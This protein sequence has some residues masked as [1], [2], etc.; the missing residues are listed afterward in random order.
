M[1]DFYHMYLISNLLVPCEVTHLI[2]CQ[3]KVQDADLKKRPAILNQQQ[4]KI[5]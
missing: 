5:K 1:R 2:L 3:I 4:F